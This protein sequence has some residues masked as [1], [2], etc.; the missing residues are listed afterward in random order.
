LF[1]GVNAHLYNLS[2]TLLCVIVFDDCGRV[3]FL[4]QITKYGSHHLLD[5][6]LLSIVLY[7]W[8]LYTD[9]WITPAIIGPY[10]YHLDLISAPDYNRTLLHSWL[11][12]QLLIPP[13]SSGSNLA[14]CYLDLFWIMPRSEFLI[15]SSTWLS[16]PYHPG[17]LI[18]T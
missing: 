18:H 12:L 6:V 8:K 15:Y 4:I 3:F 11:H 10:L 2:I 1:S 13:L 16:A 5:S 9:I 14:G 17:T 7:C